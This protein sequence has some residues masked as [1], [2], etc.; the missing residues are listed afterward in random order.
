M[1]LE[2][3]K[4]GYFLIGC[5]LIK[6]LHLLKLLLKYRRPLKANEIPS[7]YN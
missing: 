5:L 6:V 1:R 2:D 7:P 3:K 4:A